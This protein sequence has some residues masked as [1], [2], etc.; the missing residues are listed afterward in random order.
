MNSLNAVI[1]LFAEENPGIRIFV[2]PHDAHRVF[3][4]VVHLILV[5]SMGKCYDL[6]IFAKNYVHI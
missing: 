6:L 1:S 3:I 5:R 4:C 2:H